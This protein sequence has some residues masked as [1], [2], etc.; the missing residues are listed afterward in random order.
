MLKRIIAVFIA[1]MG[2][3][4]FLA[5][6]VASETDGDLY[7]FCPYLSTA[8]Y[9][10]YLK[11][12][13]DLSSAQA[14]LLQVTSDGFVSGTLVY[15]DLLQ[16]TFFMFSGVS[17]EF[18]T[19]QSAYISCSLKEGSTLKNIPMILWAAVIQ[20]EYYGQIEETGSSFLDWVNEG[21]E[22]GEMFY[23][24]YFIATYNE[25]PRDSCSLLLI[26]L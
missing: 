24:P 2:I 16:E 11:S 26:R 21:R 17:G 23:S 22:D 8:R 18:D 9:N 19:A 14:A 10:S 13:L 12:F 5:P 3:T 7:T 25:T 1:V 20:L 6:A 4:V 15:S